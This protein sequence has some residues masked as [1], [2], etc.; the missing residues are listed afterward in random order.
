MDSDSVSRRD[1]EELQKFL[2]Q[3]IRLAISSQKACSV[4]HSREHVLLEKASTLARVE[5]NRRLEGMN[6]LR[7]Q[8]ERAEGTYI[9]RDSFQRDHEVLRVSTDVRFR[10]IERLIWMACGGVT[11][12][13]TIL[14]LISLMFT[15][16]RPFVP[17]TATVIK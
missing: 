7:S 1:L 5:M 8:L 6:A 17:P 11:V 15:W 3:K 13:S 9:T 16:L 4:W 14:T 2:E 10:A 12:I